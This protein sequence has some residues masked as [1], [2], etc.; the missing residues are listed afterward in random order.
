M[1]D[2]A[3]LLRGQGREPGTV[4]P[5]VET[6]FRRRMVAFLAPMVGGDYELATR[7]VVA[8]VAGDAVLISASD[9]VRH[10]GRRVNAGVRILEC[11][12]G[13]LGRKRCAGRGYIYRRHRDR[14]TGGVAT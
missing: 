6:G 12:G 11:Y 5:G 10:H 9:G 7:S 4:M 13:S 3:C 1:A 8:H 14:S 2:D